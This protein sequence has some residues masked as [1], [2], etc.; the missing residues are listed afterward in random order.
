[1]NKKTYPCQR[2][3]I[4]NDDGIDAMGLSVL[5]RIAEQLAPEVWV[6]APEA[7]RS[8]ASQCISLHRTIQIE[9]R[10]EKE[11]AIT[12][13]PADCVAIAC[14]YVMA[15]ALPD[16]I[17]SGINRGSNLGNET[18]FSGTIGG[19]LTGILFGIHSVALSL[20]HRNKKLKPHWDTPEVHGPHVLKSLLTAGWPKDIC[21]NV[22]FP[23]APPENCGSVMFTRQGRGSL[24]GFKIIMMPGEG[25]RVQCQIELKHGQ[26]EKGFDTESG[27]VI[28]NF[29]SVT[30]IQLNRTDESS[31]LLLELKTP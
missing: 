29:I 10:G 13:T 21:L 17:L 18:V 20:A 22:N 28:Q 24:N 12:G 15:D 19:A 16:L 25:T 23:D 27:S 8:G 2:I 9:Q 11:Y 3:L 31:R 26:M 30:P 5:K 1:M 14:G 4:T 7:E 6:F